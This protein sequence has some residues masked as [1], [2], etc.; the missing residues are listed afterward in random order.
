MDKY[1][2]MKLQKYNHTTP[3]KPQHYPLPSETKKYDKDSQ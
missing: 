3:T 2:P 1:V